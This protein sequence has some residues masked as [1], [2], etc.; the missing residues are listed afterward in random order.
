MVTIM[1]EIDG[2][3]GEGGGQLLRTALSLSCITGKSFRISNIRKSRPKS[4]LMRQHL[5]AVQ[6]AA[7]IA[8]AELTGDQLGSTELSFSPRRVTPGD[9]SFDIGTAGSTPLVLQTIIPPLLLAGGP[10]RLTLTG[11][12]HVP[13]SP[14]FHYIA[15]VFAPALYR[16]GARLELTLDSCGFYPK[17]GGKVRCRIQPSAAFTALNAEQRGKLLRISGCSAVANLPL[18]IAERQTRSALGR[19]ET[20]LGGFPEQG[21]AEGVPPAPWERAE[22]VPLAPR[23]RAEGV[24]LAPRERGRGEGVAT[25]GAVPTE[26]PTREVTAYGQGTFIFI[27]GEYEHAVSGFTALGARGKPA[28]AVGEEAAVEFLTHHQTGMP[29]DPH[30]ADQLVLYLALAKGPSVF[31]TSRITGH[32]E[33]NLVVAGYFLDIAVQITGE[34]DAPGTVKI[35]PKGS[36]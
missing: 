15:E 12:T 26:L 31:A 22:G 14:S 23:E 21:S 25:Y 2:S 29:I 19:L 7:R 8:G 11:G 13:F 24:P 5:V 18:S 32:L 36:R 28:E 34:R 9:Y 30:L 35:S 27:R 16:L 17:G 1:I 3:Q 20:V 4:G 6:A 33:T 10:S